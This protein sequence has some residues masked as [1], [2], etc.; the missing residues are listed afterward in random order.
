MT[1]RRILII[2]AHPDDCDI[3]AGGS[4]V[5]WRNKGHDVWFV[6]VA[7]GCL[8]H[9][10]QAGPGLATRR[11]KEAERAGATI[12]VEYLVMDV[13]DGEVVPSVELRLEIIRLI[14]RVRPDIV[15]SHRLNDYHPDHRATAQLVLD[16]A[17]MLT[18]PG[19]AADTPFLS[20][21]PV[22]GYLAD[23][24]EQPVPFRPDYVLPTD[25][26]MPAVLKMLACHESQF[27]EWLPYNQEVLDQ[28]PDDAAGRMRFLEAFFGDRFATR[29]DRFRPQ[30]VQLLG[31]EKGNQVRWADAYEI[32][33]YGSPMDEGLAQDLFAL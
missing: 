11:K 18:V 5:R 9:Q 12:G 28:V 29:A 22:F 20:R 21:A 27:F 31:E 24:F 14:R 4:A 13:P 17:Y 15:L 30:L 23:A 26:Q 1:H 3:K 16:S 2:G 8:G 33:E 6:S 32:S 7:N 10:N 25:E 19:Y